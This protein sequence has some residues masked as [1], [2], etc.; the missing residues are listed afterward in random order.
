MATKS[1]PL[2]EY[3]GQGAPA[4]VAAPPKGKRSEAD[5]LD[6][7]L[8]FT[9]ESGPAIREA[10][11]FGGRLLERAGIPT[12][13]EGWKQHYIRGPL[14]VLF[15]PFSA[16]GEAVDTG[17][18]AAGRPRPVSP[19]WTTPG[20]TPSLSLG[21][22][23][24]QA[25]GVLPLPLGPVARGAR[26]LLGRR[27][28]I[29]VPPVPQPGP[30]L[31]LPPAARPMPE[32]WEP[33]PPRPVRPYEPHA[34]LEIQGRPPEVL[35]PIRDLTGHGDL[36]DAQMRPIRAQGAPAASERQRL[37]AVGKSRLDPRID[38]EGRAPAD[39][40]PAEPD[41][42]Q[43]D[44]GFRIGRTLGRPPEPPPPP[45]PEPPP[46]TP[47]WFNP[48]KMPPKPP[49]PGQGWTPPG[50]GGRRAEVPL[51]VFGLDFEPPS[52]PGSLPRPAPPPTPTPNPEVVL[53]NYA[54]PNGT[55]VVQNIGGELVTWTK[56]D[57]NEWQGWV[58]GAHR[59]V[60][61]ETAL[62]MAANPPQPAPP[63]VPAVRQGAPAP[64]PPP[65]PDVAPAPLAPA[66]PTPPPALPG[67][68]VNPRALPV[69]PKPVEMVNTFKPEVISS[70][71][72][73]RQ[74]PRNVIDVGQRDAIAPP[75]GPAG[76]GPDRLAW[77]DARLGQIERTLGKGIGDR[78]ELFAERD[79][80]RNEVGRIHPDIPGNRPFKPPPPP[81][82]VLPA[83]P[84]RGPDAPTGT[85][86]PA[87]KAKL[88]ARIERAKQ[89]IK[90]VEASGD[91]YQRRIA[92]EELYTAWSAADEAQRNANI[93]AFNAAYRAAKPPALPSTPQVPGVRPD[94]PLPSPEQAFK[95]LLA[96]GREGRLSVQPP[97]PGAP[98]VG[99]KPKPPAFD[100]Q[101]GGLDQGLIPGAERSAQQ[102]ST[103]KLRPKA[104]QADLT[105]NPL[106]NPEG[107]ARAEALDRAQGVLGG[108]PPPEPPT[109]LRSKQ[110]EDGMTRRIREAR[111]RGET[112]LSFSGPER[113]EGTSV[114][115]FRRRLS[116]ANARHQ[117]ALDRIDAFNRT[118][119]ELPQDLR[120]SGI[121]R[122]QQALSDAKDEV[123]LA[124]DL[125]NAAESESPRKFQDMAARL[126]AEPS[127]V[128]PP[129]PASLARPEAPKPPPPAVPK[130]DLPNV[131]M[132]LR[133]QAN[134]QEWIGDQLNPKHFMALTRAKSPDAIHPAV[135]RAL[136]AK[137]INP[138]D[139]W[140]A[141]Q[142][143]FPSGVLDR[144][145]AQAE[146]RPAL[147][148]PKPPPKPKAPRAKK[149]VFGEAGV[150]DLTDPD[151]VSSLVHGYGKIR[152]TDDLRGELREVPGYFKSPKGTTLDHMAESIVADYPHLGT[153]EDVKEGLLDT[154]R[155]YSTLKREKADRLAK[156]K[157]AWQARAKVESTPDK[158]VG[159]K[160]KQAM[161][162][163]SALGQDES[164]ALKLENFRRAWRKQADKLPKEMT[165]LRDAPSS[166]VVSAIERASNWLADLT[167][168]RVNFSWHK[169]VRKADPEALMDAEETAV[170]EWIA[171]GKT[172]AAA[173]AAE[174]HF[175]AS[176]QAS[177]RQREDLFDK[178]N[179]ARRFFGID[180]VKRNLGPY[181]PR[182]VEDGR[183]A[184]SLRGEGFG[185]QPLLTTRPGGH[186]EKRVFETYREG[187]RKGMEYMDPRN[188]ILLRDFDDM[189][190]VAT[191]RL[192]QELEARKAIFRD[193]AAAKA[194]SPSG[195]P[196]AIEHAPGDTTW[197]APTEA[198][199]KFL[200]QNLKP[201]G[202]GPLGTLAHYANSLFRN[203]NLLNPLPHIVKNM[204]YKLLLADGPVNA[205]RVAK[206][207]VEFFRRSNPAMLKEF[208]EAMPFSATGRT[209]GDLLERGM[210]RPGVGGFIK[211]RVGDLGVI[212]RPSQKVIFEW[213]D[214]AM[215][216]SLFKHYREQGMSPFE[217]GNNAW[218]DLI[219][220]GTRSDRVDFWKK[221]PLNF[222][223][224][225]R[226]GTLTS[227]VKQAKNHPI[228]AAL[229]VGAAEYIREAVYRQTGYW[230]HYPSDYAQKPLASAAQAHSLKEAGLNL[231]AT[232]ATT[233][234]MGPGGDFSAKQLGEAIEA[235]RGNPNSF[236][237]DRLRNAFWGISQFYN[238][239]AEFKRGDYA[240]I[241]ATATLGAHRALTYE[242]KRFTSFIPE[243]L[244]GMTKSDAVRRAE[245]MQ[246]L[247]RERV[248][249]RNERRDKRGR[250][251]TIEDK[252]RKAGMI[253]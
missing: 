58:G 20:G 6:Q 104:P 9:D 60:S 235:I 245:R 48:S 52:S 79:R 12:T 190:A 143:D 180:A 144:L 237:W 29:D 18:E 44:Q 2:D 33:P 124:R 172:P 116:I 238:M 10:K 193:E 95:D 225:W 43:G 147:E 209:A 168:Q 157:I 197:Y 243:S 251:P 53:R 85:I 121:A 4:A 236:E 56:S 178:A 97:P 244:P 201:N 158:P 134:I 82:E 27:A 162:F 210:V 83:P 76:S 216:Y 139:A 109:S 70:P 202:G 96:G 151:H 246:E 206:D 24:E 23:A 59:S 233:A 1:D 137:G 161:D 91:D 126:K 112:S 22:M 228:R 129:P 74:T 173:T 218:I 87:L 142:D 114:E 174:R 198:E 11:G 107:A 32:S 94:A 213:A 62:N 240:G 113:V 40:G 17:A 170:K 239:G 21:T 92:N 223:V 241:L 166:P 231:G 150:P 118:A 219:R 38:L 127:R 57:R 188:A 69:P 185:G 247:R 159:L 42:P 226:F 155:R 133:Q 54:A 98:S 252:L 229:T 149:D 232:A 50:T 207:S 184:V 187:Q 122:R 220:Y 105:A 117:D 130:V 212:N 154:L 47:D 31:A 175:P 34:P 120:D 160:L 51:D 63:P 136:E 61:G 67:P 102:T 221:M 194:A 189:K 211:R 128:S 204:G 191:H 7:Y 165:V 35:G 75:E 30:Q 89:R 14:G 80:L 8:A 86:D 217:A 195:R 15:S 224:P 71:A 64:P 200:A 135:A 90:E 250:P 66:A 78:P 101:A 215:R 163:F 99:G 123:A 103:A 234:L 41:L 148:A 249:Q 93:D 25:A 167:Q 145:A 242:P 227:L 36:L 248:E 208:H 68:R 16:L 106:L 177:L 138:T 181:L 214:P 156:D 108:P 253:R 141:M 169:A 146:G 5:P 230:W 100:R 37:R 46:P 203:P 199:A 176:V 77:L 19:E 81:A 164:G 152:V 192:F 28:P 132:M 140:H 182:V 183:D 88:D 119:H 186:G 196:W 73:G 110:P 205:A 49:V 111:E 26:A 55:K 171:N 72:E 131:E 39:V 3:L 84:R 13:T 45:R 65:A 222:F 115:D 153:R 125:L 179:A